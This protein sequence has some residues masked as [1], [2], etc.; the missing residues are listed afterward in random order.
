MMSVARIRK[1]KKTKRR[2]HHLLGTSE[3][4]SEEDKAR[5]SPEVQGRCLTC[6]RRKLR[7]QQAQQAAGAQGK[8]ANTAWGHMSMHIT[9]SRVLTQ[10]RGR[11][12]ATESSLEQSCLFR[13]VGSGELGVVTGGLEAPED[14]KGGWDRKEEAQAVSSHSQA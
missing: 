10:R 5:R 14:G 4:S 13:V 3:R 6:C 9:E 8:E 2:G 1:K 12:R 7:T 11:S